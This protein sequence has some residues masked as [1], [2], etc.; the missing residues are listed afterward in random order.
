MEQGNCLIKKLS[1]IAYAIGA[2]G[3]GY[4]LWRHQAHVFQ[5]LPYLLLL[6]CPLMHLF[7]GHGH[8]D[9]HKKCSH[10]K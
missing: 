8:H 1:W 6:A 3:V 10:N 2:A 9:D 5:Y 4:F 7:G